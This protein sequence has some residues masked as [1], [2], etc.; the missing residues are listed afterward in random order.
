MFPR[1]PSIRQAP[2]VDPSSLFTRNFRSSFLLAEYRQCCAALRKTRHSDCTIFLVPFAPG[3]GKWSG[4]VFV[5]NG[6]FRDGIF[7]FIISYP[8]NF[9]S[10]GD[11]V[12]PMVQFLGSS[13]NPFLFPSDSSN[14]GFLEIRHL[15]PRLSKSD[16]C[17][18]CICRFIQDIFGSEERL[19]RMMR[20]LPED[21]QRPDPRLWARFMEDRDRFVSMARSIAAECRRQALEE[22]IGTEDRKG[23][24]PASPGQ[25]GTKGPV[26]QGKDARYTEFVKRLRTSYPEFVRAES[27]GAGLSFVEWYASTFKDLFDSSV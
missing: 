3:D 20:E 16:N 6:P 7:R 12:F 22:G 26:L 10:A 11:G 1:S 13:A 9:P 8:S 23:L 25:V 21:W 14:A 24:A 2:N 18:L 19:S 5:H 27:E 4:T 15:L 17:A